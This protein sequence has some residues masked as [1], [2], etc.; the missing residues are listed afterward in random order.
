ML[1][2]TELKTFLKE[3]MIDDFIYYQMNVKKNSWI[4][5]NHITK[6]DVFCF[7]MRQN[8]KASTLHKK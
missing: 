2:N 5:V 1:I 4:E 6:T 8:Q 7:F 3:R